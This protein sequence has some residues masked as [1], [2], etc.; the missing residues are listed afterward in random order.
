[1][2]R[3]ILLADDS[4]TIQRLV[5]QTF[6][7]GNFEVVAVSNGD[8]AIRKFEEVRPELVLADIYMPGKNGYEVCAVVKKHPELGGTP[9]V[10]LA[11]AFDAYDEET[12]SQVGAAAHI[13]KPFEPHAL[14]NLV[15]SLLPKEAPK[16]AAAGAA[17][18]VT[19]TIPHPA[20]M[21]KESALPV[22]APPTPVTP[23]APPAKSAGTPRNLTKEAETG[24]LL[25]LN[26][27][28]QPPAAERLSAASFSDELIDR[29][30][31]RVIKKLSTQ[32]IES[33][34][35]DVVPEITAKVLR[36]ELK[37]QS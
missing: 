12:A 6:H 8:A 36:E 1:M 37:R 19:S 35:W 24:D 9:V 10:L 11:G 18:P 30:A 20:S 15:V 21:P 5:A 34:A 29:I 16:R 3:L 28:F 32:V 2:K 7:D 25:G 17:Q 22:S 23:V 33:V 4:P 14:V 26:A 31:D 13:T 27:L